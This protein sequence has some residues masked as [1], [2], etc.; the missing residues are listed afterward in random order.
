MR[1][2]EFKQ[3]L[4]E[5]AKVGRDYQHLE[6]LVF[7]DGSAGANEAA[8]ILDKLGKDTSDVSISI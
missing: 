4:T 8:D 3:V 2:Q 5:A 7:V 6:D 1:F